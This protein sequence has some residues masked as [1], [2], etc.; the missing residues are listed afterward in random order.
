VNLIQKALLM[1]GLITI[2]IFVIIAFFIPIMIFLIISGVTYLALKEKQEQ[3]Q[4]R[5]LGPPS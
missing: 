1:G 5:E 3:S 4:S 2:G